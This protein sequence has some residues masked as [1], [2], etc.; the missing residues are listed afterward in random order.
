MLT[1]L[2]SLP[3]CISLPVH[4]SFQEQP[5]GVPASAVS[6]A[7]ASVFGSRNFSIVTSERVTYPKF[8]GRAGRKRGGDKLNCLLSFFLHSVVCIL[9]SPIKASG[10][11][12]L[13]LLYHI[14]ADLCVSNVC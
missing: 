12:R 3:D 1:E 10:Q 13:R 4:N 8:A 6:I 9:G 7:S 14:V 2:A 5:F 11:K